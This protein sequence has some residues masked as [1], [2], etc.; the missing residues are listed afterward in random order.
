MSFYWLCFAEFIRVLGIL[1]FSIHLIRAWRLNLKIK[2]M[3]NFKVIA[4]E[5]IG[6]RVNLT[7]E[8]LVKVLLTHL[9]LKRPIMKMFIV[10][11]STN[12]DI[13]GYLHSTCKHKRL[14]KL[15]NKTG[16]PSVITHSKR[17]IGP[18]CKWMKSLK[19]KTHSWKQE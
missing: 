9:L 10:K 12:I 7:P 17:L 16:P 8:T 19:M 18:T 14:K 3:W 6:S 5:L 1:I 4:P 15:W 13:K 11:M 2:I